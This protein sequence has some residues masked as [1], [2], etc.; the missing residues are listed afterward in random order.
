MRLRKFSH[1]FELS[2]IS[3]EEKPICTKFAMRFVEFDR[4]PNNVTNQPNMTRIYAASNAARSEFRFH[5]NNLDEFMKFYRQYD[6][7]LARITI[8]EIPMFIP[9]PVEYAF[10]T[11]ITLR[12]AQVPQC[13]FI[14]AEGNAKLI[15]LQPGAGKTL[16]ALYCIAQLKQRAAIILKGGYIDRWIPDL[17][18]I[19]G[20][21][22]NQLRI[23]RGLGAMADL[24]FEAMQNKLDDKVIVFST[25]TL[26]MYQ[27]HYEIHNGDMSLF[28]NIPPQFLW[29]VL[30]VGIRIIDEVH[31]L[32]H[33]NFKQD[34]YTHV[35]K[36]LCLSATVIPGSD[37]LK[38]YLYDTMF[39]KSTR[40]D[41]GVYKKYVDAY[42]LMYNLD[43][44]SQTT[45]RWTRKGGKD[46]S[47]TEF[48]KSILKNKKVRENYINFIT[49]QVEGT[50]V[51]R[52]TAN[53]KLLVFCGTVDLCSV[54]AKHFQSLW[55]EIR[56]NKYTSEDDYKIIAQSDIIVSTVGSL[57]T[58]HDIPDLWQVHL[59]VGLGKEDTNIQVIGRMRE[60]KNFPGRT[61]EMYYYAC[62]DIDK[63]MRYHNTK[64]ELYK[65]RVLKHE[66][67]D[68]G[69]II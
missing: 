21:E 69:V 52:K 55:P 8:D 61:P 39:P 59:T 66:I 68:T 12:E 22:E 36:T 42:A 23:V 44:K 32:F 51:L 9:M 56:T 14:L 40:V 5:I 48:E 37:P 43:Y 47:Q 34:L 2:E 53:E 7:N 6:I 60:M 1:H 15:E 45:L 30:G 26:R 63:H 19:L 28:A 54:I 58:A 10:D 3:V 49:R 29:E 62:R 65:P 24:C 33:A 31:Q 67:Y 57:G 27:D 25:D 20:L 38:K 50:F 13:N 17:I 16:I 41:N 18:K 11:S 46:Y 4:T 35:P 64:V